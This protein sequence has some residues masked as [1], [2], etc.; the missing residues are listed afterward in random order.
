VEEQV[1]Y[2][3]WWKSRYLIYD[4]GRAGILYTMVEEQVSYIRC[5]HETEGA[6]RRQAPTGVW[7]SL[8]LD[9][10]S[11]KTVLDRSPT[12]FVAIA[13]G[14]APSPAMTSD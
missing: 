7:E 12:L 2:I 9:I 14:T 1:S 4:G 3:R 13:K 10:S 5:E 11:K 6:T 8:V